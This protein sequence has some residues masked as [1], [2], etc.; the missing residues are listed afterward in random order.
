MIMKYK[1]GDKV[2]VKSKDWYDENKD[3]YGNVSVKHYFTTEM[4]KWCGKEV[5]IEEVIDDLYRIKNDENKWSWSDE[6]FEDGI[7]EHNGQRKFKCKDEVIVRYNKPGCCWFYGVVSHSGDDYIVLSGGFRYPYE[8]YDVLPYEGKEHLVGTTDN[9]DERITIEPD[10]LV[11]VFN[12]MENLDK[13]VLALA[14][15]EFVNALGIFCKESNTCWE[16]C[17]PF[18]KFNPDD[19]EATKKEILMVKDGKLVKA[20]V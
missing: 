20:N 8:I 10:E 13:M 9:P 3:I 2:R 19:I 7:V 17:I 12:S 15:V 4:S 18:S 1:V 14:R 5:I 11:Y 16:Y 6:M